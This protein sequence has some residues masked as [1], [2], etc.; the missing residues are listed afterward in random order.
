MRDPY[1]YSDSSSMPYVPAMAIKIFR[2]GMYS[3]NI[4]T[5]TSL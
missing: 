3:A 1:D 2:D 5:I 4:L